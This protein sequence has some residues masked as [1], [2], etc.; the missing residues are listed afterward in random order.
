MKCQFLS[1]WYDPFP[2]KTRLKR[3]SNL[4]FSAL[5]ADALITRPTK[6][7][8]WASRPFFRGH[9]ILFTTEAGLTDC[10]ALSPSQDRPSSTEAGLTDCRA[11]SPSQDRPSSTE[12]GL[13]DCRALCPSQDRPS[14]T[15]ASLTDCRALC[16]SQDRPSSTEA[17][18]TDCRALCPSQDRPSSTSTCQ[19]FVKRSVL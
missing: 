17:G 1:H 14:S 12:A 16:P 18:L 15:E 5:E 10:K 4:G 13:T 2:K 7:W 9:L 11:L 6:R 3:N 8:S 19:L